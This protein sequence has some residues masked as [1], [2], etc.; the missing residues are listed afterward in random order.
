MQRDRPRKTPAE[1]EMGAQHREL[2]GQVVHRHP[3]VETGFANSGGGPCG[4]QSLKGFQP[5]GRALRLPPG[6][7]A[8]GGHRP[9]NAF[10]QPGDKRPVRFARAVDDPAADAGA[11]ARSEGGLKVRRKTGVLEVAVGVGEAHSE[12]WAKA[13]IAASTC[14]SPWR[15]VGVI[16]RSNP[17][18][19]TTEQAKEA[20]SPAVE[21]V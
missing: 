3:A 14:V 20:T 9:V 16:R 17:A 1:L 13:L 12:C 10:L 8:E 18:S 19:A 7:Q 6:V 2:V 21:P 5:V 15:R 11:P 4:K